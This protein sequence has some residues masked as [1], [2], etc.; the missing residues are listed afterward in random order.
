M[1]KKSMQNRGFNY[2][3]FENPYKA[4]V[5]MIFVQAQSDLEELDGEERVYRNG[6]V[7]SKWEIINFLRSGWGWFLANSVGVEATDYER[8]VRLVLG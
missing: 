8:Y 4:L 2:E 1:I 3:A 5:A 7:I 6:N